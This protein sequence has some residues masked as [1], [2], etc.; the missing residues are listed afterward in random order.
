MKDRIL[1]IS[2][3]GVFVGGG[4]HSFFDLLIRLRA[5]VRI[6]GVVPERA[7]LFSRLVEEGIE[8]RII[9]LPALRPWYTHKMLSSLTAFRKLCAAYRPTLIYA[10]GSRAA[11]YGCIIGRF[12]GI[13]VI[14]HCR[15]AEHDPYL[16][17]FLSR[18]STVIIANSHATAKRFK[19]SFSGKIRVV[20]NGIDLLRLREN[21]FSIPASIGADW[22]MILVIARISKWKRHDLALGAFERVAKVEPKAHLVCLGARDSLDPGWWDHMHNMTLNS[23]FPERI[24]WIGQVNDIRPWL[25]SASML[26]LPSDN[27]SFGRVLVEAMAAGVPVVGTRSGGAPEI[28]REGLD[29]LLVAPGDAFE[30]SDAILKLINDDGLRKGFS[31]SGRNRAGEF[32]LER[33]LK[34]M[35]Q[36]FEETMRCRKEFVAQ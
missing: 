23:T 11:F 16:D 21:T 26:L 24:H 14:W 5:R 35:V 10:N 31:E 17:P 12:M 3:H 28:V 8:T 34:R 25:K 4:E 36:V 30:M 33:H 32:S 2:N 18:L 29:G 6:L 15:I 9:D 27:E 19:T 7:Q 22:K 13:P 1:A 20:H